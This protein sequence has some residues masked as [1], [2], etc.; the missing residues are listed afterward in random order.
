MNDDD[1]CFG[2]FLFLLVL[3]VCM[4]AV[5]LVWRWALGVMGLVA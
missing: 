3:P 1:G 5:Y 2:C 4:V